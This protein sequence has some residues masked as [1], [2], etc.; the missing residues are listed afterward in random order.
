MNE[1]VVALLGIVFVVLFAIG[2]VALCL[3]FTRWTKRLFYRSQGTEEVM[4]ILS[5]GNLLQVQVVRN[6]N[7]CQNAMRN[8]RTYVCFE[9][10]IHR[11]E[12][13]E[14][15][16]FYYLFRHCVD[17]NVVGIH[18]ISSTS[19]VPD[20]IVLA[21]H[22]GLCVI[23]RLCFF[24]KTLPLE[25][26]VCF[27]AS[28]SEYISIILFTKILLSVCWK[29]KTSSKLECIR[30]NSYLSHCSAFTTWRPNLRT[31]SDFCRT[32]ATIHEVICICNSMNL[33]L[34]HL[35][36]TGEQKY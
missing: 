2:L 34:I 16:S 6:A 20:L 35:T 5:N 18:S 13:E 10:F 25:L 31:I 27:N 24:K 26:K 9:L 30:I 32:C 8:I 21:T 22:R 23:I 36:L 15:L 11:A 3:L 4:N 29:T 14:N 17:Y 28:K 19:R 7:E 12:H 33:E 1:A